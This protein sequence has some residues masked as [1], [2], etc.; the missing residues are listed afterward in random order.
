VR[1]R[2][3][4]TGQVLVAQPIEDCIVRL[5][6]RTSAVSTGSS[7]LNRLLAGPVFLDA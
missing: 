5:A 6:A 1:G 7:W 2:L 3:P 4:L